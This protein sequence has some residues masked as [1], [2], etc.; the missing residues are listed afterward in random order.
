MID[1]IKILSHM[2]DVRCVAPETLKETFGDLIG[3]T[4]AE[5]LNGM[6]ST[7]M[8]AILLNGDTPEQRKWATLWHEVIEW[9][10]CDLELD[11]DNSVISIISEVLTQV[12]DSNFNL[13]PKPHCYNAPIEPFVEKIDMT[14]ICGPDYVCSRCIDI[15]KDI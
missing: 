14:C 12:I 4:Q 15:G 9:I 1:K 6:F 13:D 7:K 5:E 8:N 3:E 11:L 2:V 10:S